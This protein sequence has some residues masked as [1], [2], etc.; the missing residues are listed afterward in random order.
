MY[1]HLKKDDTEEYYMQHSNRIAHYK[2]AAISGLCLAGSIVFGYEKEMLQ[3]ITYGLLL[4][5]LVIAQSMGKQLK[6]LQTKN[7]DLLG[8][9]ERKQDEFFS[10][11]VISVDI[12]VNLT[13]LKDQETGSHLKRIRSYVQLIAEQLKAN[14]IYAEYLQS[15]PHYIDDIS[16]ASV[17][18]DIGKTATPQSLLVKTERLNPEEFEIAKKHTVAAGEILRQASISFFEQFRADSCMTLAC[19][20]AHYHHEH[21]DGNGYPEGRKG[22]DTPL[23]ARIVAVADVYD[24]LTSP[25][26]YKKPWPHQMAVD[27]IRTQSGRQ[28]E[29]AIVNAFLQ[30]EERISHAQTLAI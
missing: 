6:I 17:L 24:A 10:I 27:E 18:H 21:W 20:I 19:E 28:F 3:I 15:R 30:V 1:L 25:R 11:Q 22:R 4:Y 14:S 8:T 29:P 23:S 13:K 7:D 9:I 26:P 2:I 5:F 16:L 12:L